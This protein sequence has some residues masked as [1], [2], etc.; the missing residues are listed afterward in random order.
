MTFCALSS[1]KGMDIKMKII[2][3]VFKNYPDSISA[4]CATF[5]LFGCIVSGF[6]T[7]LL[8]RKN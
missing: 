8:I 2:I 3:E 7:I 5:T 1:A 4:L 6:L